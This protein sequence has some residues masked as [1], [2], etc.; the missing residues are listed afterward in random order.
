MSNFSYA[1][2]WPA[3]AQGLDPQVVTNLEA[4]DR[5]LEQYLY[6][7][8]RVWVPQIFGDALN[9]PVNATAGF[10]VVGARWERLRG[11]FCVASVVARALGGA[12]TGG[13]LGIALPDE[14]PPAPAIPGIPNVPIGGI[15]MR[16]RYA[17]TLPPSKECI[18]LR[19][20]DQRASGAGWLVV[21]SAPTG[22]S[23]PQFT[24]GDLDPTQKDVFVTTFGWR[25]A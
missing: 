3:I 10:D 17:N 4:H 18:A 20:Y 21:Y 24:V 5:E 14:A 1:D 6:A 25:T 12:G 22:I 15:G 16:M 8:P 13:I 2:R 9:T 7:P 11:R 23:H 19:A